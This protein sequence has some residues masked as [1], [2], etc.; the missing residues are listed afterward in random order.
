MSGNSERGR[1]LHRREK[2]ATKA[3]AERF[4][5]PAAD[6]RAAPPEAHESLIGRKTVEE[7]PL[8]GLSFRFASS[9]GRGRTGNQSP[10]S[11]SV[12]MAKS[13]GDE[14]TPNP[15]AG[16]R[17]GFPE[18]DRD[19]LVG[20]A[21]PGR[22][23]K[24]VTAAVVK[25]DPYKWIC[26]LETSFKNRIEI[27]TDYVTGFLVGPRLILT[28]AHNLYKPGYALTEVKVYR[29]RTGERTWLEKTTTTRFGCLDD[30]HECTRDIGWVM[31]DSDSNAGDF[32]HCA[33][34][35]DVQPK[36]VNVA[37]YPLD[38]GRGIL[39]RGFGE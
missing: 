27:V 23:V 16:V 4:E 35:A 8:T 34:A 28:A 24:R 5:K 25:S 7:V 11:W 19:L 33:V 14:D 22:V 15:T 21:L 26:S 6:A 30:W 18:P 10:L 32:M 1:G 36:H 20:S 37:G 9:A 39:M 13:E 3:G 12:V 29:G 38:Y 2:N 31:L 17:P